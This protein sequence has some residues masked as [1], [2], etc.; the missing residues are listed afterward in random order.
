MHRTFFCRTVAVASC[1]STGSAANAVN[2]TWGSRPALLHQFAATQPPPRTHPAC[3][4]SASRASLCEALPGKRRVHSAVAAVHPAVP[5]SKNPWVLGGGVEVDGAPQCP[6]CGAELQS[7]RVTAPGYIAVEKLD[8]FIHAI[9]QWLE[10]RSRLA[11]PFAPQLAQ[12]AAASGG[13]AAAAAVDGG[14]SNVE[15]DDGLAAALRVTAPAQVHTQSL[16]PSA[17]ATRASAGAPNDRPPPQ[18][19]HQ[20][21]GSMVRPKPIVCTRCHALLNYGTARAVDVADDS[22]FEALKPLRDTANPGLAICIVDI[23]DFPGSLVPDLNTVI[24]K[25]TNVMLV[26]NKVDLLPSDTRRNQQRLMEWVRHE[27]AAA[28]VCNVGKVVLVSASTSW[29]LRSLL[30]HIAESCASQDKDAYFI[31]ATNVGK[32]S[33]INRLLDAGGGPKL[34]TS[35]SPGTTLSNL[36]FVVKVGAGGVSV[37]RAS[38]ETHGG[39]GSEYVS[40]AKGKKSAAQH[41]RQNAG[42]GQPKKK[43]RWNPRTR[44]KE[45][46]DKVETVSLYDTPGVM[47]RTH[48][49]HALTDKELLALQPATQLLPQTVRMYPGQ[50]LMLGGLSRLD[51]TAG[52]EHP[53]FIT[54]FASN[55]LHLHLT[56]T[57]K[58]DDFYAKEAAGILVP[59]YPTGGLQAKK[60]KGNGK[61]KHTAGEG[62]KRTV[63]SNYA[64]LHDDGND[65]EQGAA[66]NCG[67]VDADVD[68]GDDPETAPGV[69]PLASEHARASPPS[70]FTHSQKK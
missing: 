28:G 14:V 41:R 66:G 48:L 10:A 64:A 39:T 34:T 25:D 8:R 22:A 30:R 38:D 4:P 36:K 7:T 18:L 24:G 49:S 5:S 19:Q 69:L 31:G 23:T 51:Y 62:K 46:M 12:G 21:R 55:K 15:F 20:Q 50:S 37:V 65:V 2:S 56:K 61:C 33:L 3:T 9:G 52:P 6:G 17:A 42:H 27:A 60:R 70:L 53:M 1:S 63:H 32:S 43:A 57:L 59:P 54:V 44:Q 26:A 40:T 45:D 13:D 16:A 67:N 11:A 68:V 58:A 35:P 29:G 47:V